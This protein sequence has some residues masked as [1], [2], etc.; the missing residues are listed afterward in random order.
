MKR[1]VRCFAPGAV[2]C[3]VLALALACSPSIPSSGR[4]VW[5]EVDGKP[6]F[7]DQVERYYRS[8]AAASPGTM[9]EELALSYELSILNELINNE[10]LLNH[11]ARAGITVSEAEVDKK[12]ADLKSPY[13]QG[14]FDKKLHEQGLTMSD[15]RNEVR[16]GLI[17]EKL[18]NKEIGSRLTVTDAEVTAYYEH[19]K[20]TFNVPE[21]QYHLAQIMVSTRTD[22]QSSGAAGPAHSV[23]EAQRKIQ[24][25]YKRLRE[26]ADFA[27][28]ARQYSEDPRTAAGG[29]D[30]GFVPASA[31]A[32]DRQVREALGSL[33]VGQISGIIREAD[34]FH[35]LK[36]LGKE[37]AGQRQLSDPQV[38]NSIRQNLMNEKEQL[39]KA[40][41]IEDL[42]DRAKV[43]NYL[44]RKIVESAGNPAAVK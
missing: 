19:N 43:V 28:L 3:G 16:R 1:L 44:A 39:L 21:T 7:R 4:E 25:V 15:L 14:E 11:A 38:Q 37:E 27:A 41:Y 32:S 26:G 10:I 5:A 22:P 35:I 12:I 42:R 20:A 6:I 18:I 33:N 24:A 30:M 29:G 23:A 36:I 8:R 9:K 2:P 40:A 31:L 34:G 17:T 13:S